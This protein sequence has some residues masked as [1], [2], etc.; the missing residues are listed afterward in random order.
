MIIPTSQDYI[1]Q[2][3]MCMKMPCR[4]WVKWILTIAALR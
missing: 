4:W 2:E 1:R 3:I